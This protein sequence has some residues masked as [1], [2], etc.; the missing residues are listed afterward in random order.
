MRPDG[1]VQQ[2]LRTPTELSFGNCYTHG[3]RGLRFGSAPPWRSDT[4]DLIQG[5]HSYKNLDKDDLVKLVSRVLFV[6]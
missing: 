4:A 6:P 3:I 2:G 1:V 5:Q